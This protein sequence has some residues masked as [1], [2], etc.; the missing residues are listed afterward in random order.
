MRQLTQLETFAR[1]GYAAR[2]AVY[3][4]LGYLGLATSRVEGTSTVM[5]DLK[6]L[7]GGEIV[8]ALTA[9][10]LFGYAVFRIYGAA[11]D[12]DGDG[13][14]AK[15]I[16]RR[17]GLVASGVA[18]LALGY[19]AVGLL[20]GDGG[21]ETGGGAAADMARE[22][23]GGA[24]ILLVAAAG[25]AAAA[26]EQ[27]VKAATG[28]FMELLVHNTPPMAEAI[29][30]IGYAARAVVFAILAWQAARAGLGDNDG[31][32][33]FEGALGALRATGWGYSVVVAGLLAFGVFSLIMA[34]YARIRNE[35]LLARVRRRRTFR[36]A[37]R[38]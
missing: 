19:L 35:D 7:P 8:L 33:S 25:L 12:L 6:A 3:L 15:G 10:G 30:R 32:V 31:D 11:R 28:A 26:I 5:D 4:M 21:G 37:R 9:A 29:G 34:R 27:A 18:H 20:S 2:A 16:A 13:T 36:A 23:P 24:L 14:G 17:I 38:R 22:A 1:T